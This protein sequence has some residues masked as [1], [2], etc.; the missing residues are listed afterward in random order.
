MK[1]AI[2]NNWILK[3]LA[4]FLAVITWFVIVL[5]LDK[6]AVEEIKALSH[7]MSTKVVPI[8]L[9]MTGKPLD[10]FTVED[11]DIVLNP[12][13]CIIVGPKASLRRVF[14]VETEPVDIEGHGRTIVKDVSIVYPFEGI[15][16]K[17]R[18]VKVTI[19]IVKI[20]D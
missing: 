16:V 4:L 18:F 7:R 14:A 8:H 11:N 9:K 15:D 20:K 1:N 13:V 12:S 17:E 3:L 19:P 10:G 6:G 2:L 5:E